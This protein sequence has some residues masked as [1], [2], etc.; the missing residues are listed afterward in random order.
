MNTP[1]AS[2]KNLLDTAADNGSFKTFGQA[3]EKAGLAET[4]RGPGPY[5]VFASTDDAFGKL[6]AGRLVSRLT[7]RAGDHEAGIRCTPRVP[8]R[9]VQIERRPRP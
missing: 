7:L 3:V 1:N 8:Q 6:P 5:T 2:T 4:L 9:F